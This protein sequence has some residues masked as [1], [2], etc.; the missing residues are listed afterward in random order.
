ML[1]EAAVAAPRS[2]L[3]SARHSSLS[4]RNGGTDRNVCPRSNSAVRDHWL[5]DLLKEIVEPLS[6]SAFSIWWSGQHFHIGTF[7]R[8]RVQ[9]TTLR[10]NIFGIIESKEKNDDQDHI[11]VD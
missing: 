1:Q 3:R 11:Q 8:V 6:R 10:R 9:L 2:R 4:V 7:V 5:G